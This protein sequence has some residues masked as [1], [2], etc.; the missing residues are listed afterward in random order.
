MSV[1]PDLDARFRAAAL[2][3]GIVD[4]RYDVFESPVGELHL[5]QTDRGLCRI[6]YVGDDWEDVL[7]RQFGVRVLRSPLDEVRRELD[8]YF[9]GERKAFDL[10]IDLRV[11]P[12]HADVLRELARVP[13][14][15]TDTYGSLARKAGR[16]GAARAVGTVMNRNPI[17]IVLPC[18]RIVGASGALVGYAGGLEVKQRLLQLEGAMLKA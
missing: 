8:E 11:A 4:V 6:S 3:E 16:P 14:G 2:G 12:F 17:P 5:A 10:P 13:Y 9:E 1:T 7:A 15:Q 18:H